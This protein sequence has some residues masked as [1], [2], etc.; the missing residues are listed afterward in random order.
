MDEDN[1][2][3]LRCI[4]CENVDCEI[5]R[6]GSFL[7]LE[8]KKGCT[9]KVNDLDYAKYIHYMEEVAPFMYINTSTEYQN[10]TYNEIIDFLEYIYSCPIGQKLNHN[11][12]TSVRQFNFKN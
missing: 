12:K 3:T 11:G 6:N 4:D 1:I 9:R 10:R 2:I 5:C 7:T 8:S